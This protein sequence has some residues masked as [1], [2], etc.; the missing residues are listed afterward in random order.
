MSSAPGLAARTVA[1][2]H[3]FEEILGPVTKGIAN[4]K[5]IS[6]RAVPC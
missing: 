3:H 4:A 2:K 1:E 5:F 6:Y